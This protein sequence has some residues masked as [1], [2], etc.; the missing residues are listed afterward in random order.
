M[1]HCNGITMLLVRY[2]KV[3]T[4]NQ[5]SLVVENSS[6]EEGDPRSCD[7]ASSGTTLKGLNMSGARKIPTASLKLTFADDYESTR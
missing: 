1:G 7:Q 3:G 2:H 5:F 6:R 4:L